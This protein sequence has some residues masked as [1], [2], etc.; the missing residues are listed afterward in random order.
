VS[1]VGS[2]LTNVGAVDAS[3]SVAPVCAPPL[4]PI[5]TPGATWADEDVAPDVFVASVA[6]VPLPVDVDPALV[7]VE[8]T[9]VVE[10]DEEVVPVDATA[11]PVDDSPDAVLD[12]EPDEEDDSEDAPVVSAAATP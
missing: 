7:D 8:S 2:E 12:V 3:D 6:V 5:V 9:P 10:V 1:F 11:D 4:L